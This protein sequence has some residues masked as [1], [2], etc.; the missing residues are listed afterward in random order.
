MSLMQFLF[1][2][3]RPICDCPSYHYFGKIQIIGFHALASAMRNFAF[4]QPLF[5]SHA[6]IRCF[7][8]RQTFFL[9][10]IHCLINSGLFVWNFDITIWHYS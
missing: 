6:K 8:Y 2:G 5:Y 10:L 3:R 1:Y 4:D 9:T 7:A